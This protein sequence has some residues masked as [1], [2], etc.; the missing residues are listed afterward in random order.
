MTRYI[1]ITASLLLLN[2]A[3]SQTNTLRLSVLDKESQESIIGVTVYFES[4]EKGDISDINGKVEIKNIPDGLQEF[5]VSFVGY[6][7]IDTAL[8]FPLQQ[9]DIVFYLSESQF[10]LEG[11]T[12]TV[13][14]S[15]RTIEN[16]PTRIEYIGGEELG[17]KSVMNAANISMVLRE[18]TGIQMQQTSI[19]SGN[20]NVRIQGLDGR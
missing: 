13:G 18:S 14:R 10:E 3:F 8:L 20:T 16:I 1:L 2:I 7:Q 11:V 5:R 4:F 15:T 9:N 17:E 12:V 6:E 19:N